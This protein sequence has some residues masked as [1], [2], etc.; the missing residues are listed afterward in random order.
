[1]CF[2]DSSSSWVSVASVSCDR[3]SISEKVYNNYIF[4]KLIPKKTVLRVIAIKAASLIVVIV[5][6]CRTQL[7]DQ[8]S[9][10]FFFIFLSPST[11]WDVLR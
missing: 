8:L 11:C 10:F 5:G 4:T 6:F 9:H 2:L 3:H 1:M 7:V